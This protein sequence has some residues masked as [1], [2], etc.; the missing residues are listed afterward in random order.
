MKI[1]ASALAVAT[2]IASPAFA[3]SP[4]APSSNQVVVG[5]KYVGQD[6]DPRIRSQL[7][8]DYDTHAGGGA[9]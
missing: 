5:N 3:Q 7:I 4:Y 6:P 2:F 1:L 9:E 8:R